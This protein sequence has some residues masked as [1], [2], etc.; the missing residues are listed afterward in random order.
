[1]GMSATD[2]EDSRT[3]IV[4]ES[5]GGICSVGRGVAQIHAS[6]RAGLGGF[7]AS[8]IHDRNFDPITMALLPQDELEPLIASIDSRGYSSRLRRMIR[9]AAP[10]MRETAAA[11]A[12]GTPALP[13]FL[14][15]PEPRPD[16][17]TIPDEEIVSAFAAQ[18]GV[19][20]DAA[21]SRLFPSGRAAALLALD[22]GARHLT[23][24]GASAVLVGGVD[25]YFDVGLIAELDAEQRIL[26]SRVMDGFVPGEGAAFILLTA[27]PASESD[28]QPPRVTLLAT[29]AAEDPGHR[30]G[31]EPAR[32]EGLAHAMGALLTSLVSPPAPIQS[33]F[34]G[35]NGE[36]FPAKEW[37]VARLRH[38]DQFAPAARIDHPADCFGDAGAALGALLLVLGHAALIRG[39]RSG[40]ALVF[41]SSDRQQRACALLELVT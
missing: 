38:T 3:M 35:F 26:G 21:K 14:G 25:S 2:R 20:V 10:A 13:M 29:G 32:G 11:V 31:S 17:L 22:A 7:R 28:D 33:V 9:L 27:A 8:A 15:M 5:T 41:A 6:V 23:A 4:I 24:T 12:D 37:G 19:A 39:H 1:V 18:S 40:P 30:Y 34:A 36:N 16:A